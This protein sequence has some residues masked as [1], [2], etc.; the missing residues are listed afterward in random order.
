MKYCKK[1][2]STDL[3]PGGEFKNGIC[4][5]CRYAEEDKN[6]NYAVKLEYLKNKIRKSRV[7]QKNREAYDCIVG[8]SGGKDSTRQAHWVRDRLGMKPL[9]VCVGY[10]PK[11]MSKIGA[12]NLSNFISMGFDLIVAT[13]APKTAAQLS[14]DSF[15]NFGN[16]CKS[17][18]MTL[19]ATV[20]RL[21][22]ELGI[23]TLFWGENP[24]LQ[25]GDKNVEGL[26]EFDGNKIRNMN[27][28]STGGRAWIDDSVSKPYLA[29]HYI[30]PDQIEFEKSKINIFYLGPVWDDWSNLENATY[31]SL[32]GLTLRPDDED[33]TGDLSNASMLDEEFTN[34]NMMLKYYKFGFGRATDYVD[35][36]IRH[37]VMKREEAIRIVKKYD[38]LCSDA[39]IKRYCE[40]VG[41][42]TNDFW[43]ITYKYVNKDLFKIN[44]K[45]RP[46]PLFNVGSN[47]VY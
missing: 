10:P 35:E 3:R 29:N 8:V 39:I 19:F 37:G 40:Y 1:C 9:I 13:P 28:L 41:I 32:Q 24:A 20:P 25:V 42:S 34:I 16:V 4:L 17:T 22:V 33:E 27:T 36:K 31:A 11:Q 43:E 26:D 18:E 46:T 2:L 12:Q 15:K 38:G 30:Y 44:K 45:G 7:G 5:P 47:N 21:A 23:N 6:E 14:L